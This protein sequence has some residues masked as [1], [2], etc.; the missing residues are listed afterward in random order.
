MKTIGLMILFFV[1]TAAGFVKSQQYIESRNVLRGFILL[2]S[3]IK[4]EI[5]SYLTPQQE[6]YEKFYDK[7]LEKATFLSSLRKNSGDTPFAQ[8]VTETKDKLFLSDEAFELLY[9]FGMSFGTLSEKE[10][11]TRCEKL[12]GELEEIYKARKEET[13]EKTRL[14]RTVG[15]MTGI[16]LVLLMW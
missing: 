2:I 16:A 3:F 8:A 7:S 6:I 15:C 10:E 4:R 12:I 5:T 9:E 11:V 13:V 1:P 14:C